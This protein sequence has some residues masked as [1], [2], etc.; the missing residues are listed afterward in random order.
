MRHTISFFCLALFAALICRATNSVADETDKPLPVPD[1]AALDEAK[2]TVDRLYKDVGSSQIIKDAKTSDDEPALK[3]V[4]L[5]R[6]IKVAANSGDAETA[7]EAVDV[8]VESFQVDAIG[9][10]TGVI[11]QLHGWARNPQ[12]FKTVFNAARPLIDEAIT[13]DRY[14]LAE[15]LTKWTLDSAKR[16]DEYDDVKEVSTLKKKVKMLAKAFRNLQDSLRIVEE[17]ETDPKSNLEVGRYYCLL[18]GEWDRGLHMLALGDNPKLK[19]LAKAELNGAALASEQKQ[20]G[21]NW[22][23][24]VKSERGIIRENL[25]GRVAYWYN[26]ALPGL[27]VVPRREVEKWLEDNYSQAEE[28]STLFDGETLRGWQGFPAEQWKVR[29]GAILGHKTVAGASYLTTKKP[30]RDFILKVQFKL[31]EGNSGIVFRCQ[32]PPKLH[33][34]GYHADLAYHDDFNYMG[35]LFGKGMVRISIPEVD[36]RK[37]I[38]TSIKR[39]DWNN[40]VITAKGNH[41]ILKIN[42]IVT[43]DTRHDG[44]TKGL[45]GFHLHGGLKPT[46]IAFKNIRIKKL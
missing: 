14:E 23:N 41:I 8:M 13:Q 32:N 27:A 42:G 3:Y 20:L 31:F 34:S 25:K 16:S 1:K 28:W 15:Q 33:L 39:S 36:T 6:A 9:L 19:K 46:K 45:I 40:Y 21:D 12:Q 17:N 37:A 2:K 43:V 18:K 29:D 24:I 7:M 35:W 22:R 26:K 44:P 30:F 11:S 5:E 10:K 4:L 38:A